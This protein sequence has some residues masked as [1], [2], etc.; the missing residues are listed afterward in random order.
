MKRI[1]IRELHM[2]T[3]S[4]IREA[5]REEQIIVT[6]R[7]EPVAVVKAYTDAETVRSFAERRE[8]EA[9]LRLPN[10]DLDSTRYLSDD[11]DRS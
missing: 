11:R 3:G 8:S 6:D 1:T 7:G 4:W 2:R 9:F 10:I 5:A